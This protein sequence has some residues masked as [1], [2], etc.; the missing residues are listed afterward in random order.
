VTV[1]GIGVAVL[2]IAAYRPTVPYRRLSFRRSRRV[3]QVRVRPRLDHGVYRV[4]RAARRG[5]RGDR[6]PRD[7]RDVGFHQA[8][9]RAARANRGSWRWPPIC[10][11]AAAARRRRRTP[12]VALIRLTE[13]RYHH[14]GLERRRGVPEVAQGGARRSHR[15]DRLL[16]GRQPELPLRDEQSGAARVRRVLRRR[17]RHRRDAADPG[18]RPRRVRRER[19]AR[20]TA[21]VPDAAT[22]LKAAGRDYRYTVYAGVGHGFLR[23]TDKPAVADTAWAAVMRFFRDNLET[24]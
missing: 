9:H 19:R 21:N 8:D 23:Q 13:C 22:A 12:R 15:C 4:S 24:K 3:H 1:A 6:D 10:S 11:R 18:P 14:A 17:A 5:A 20:I 2:A 16:L 7:L